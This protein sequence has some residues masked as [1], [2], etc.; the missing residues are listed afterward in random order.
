VKDTNQKGMNNMNDADR[1]ALVA[2]V[3]EVMGDARVG[4]SCNRF[5]EM[6]AKL[7]C[8]TSSGATRRVF[9]FPKLG[10]VIKFPDESTDYCEQEVRFYESAKAYGVERLLLPIEKVGVTKGGIPLY[11]QPIYKFTIAEM[12]CRQQEMVANRFRKTRKV[13]T[14]RAVSHGCYYAPNK[15]WMARAIQL[16]GKKFMRSFEEWTNTNHVNDLHSQNIGYIGNFRP[17]L[18]DYAGYNNWW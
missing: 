9:I 12:G 4:F 16:Y 2:R 13:A 5:S 1:Q 3:I 15:D 14:V 17:V 8:K 18:I 10:V 6:G 7:K 11:I